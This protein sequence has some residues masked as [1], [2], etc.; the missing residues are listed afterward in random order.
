LSLSAVIQKSSAVSGNRFSEAQSM[1]V[2]FR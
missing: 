1:F 2:S